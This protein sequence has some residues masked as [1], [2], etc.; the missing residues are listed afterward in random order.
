MYKLRFRSVE[1]PR[2]R[3]EVLRAY[4]ELAHAEDPD[5]ADRLWR[6]ADAEESRLTGSRGNRHAA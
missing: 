6:L 3:I 4:S 1:N 5:L 2:K